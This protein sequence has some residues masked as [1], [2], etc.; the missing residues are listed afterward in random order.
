T[1]EACLTGRLRLR[2][3]GFDPD[4]CDY[5]LLG[6]VAEI[7]RRYALVC[8]ALDPPA[9]AGLPGRMTLFAG[10]QLLAAVGD[11]LARRV[12]IVDAT[13]AA[14]PARL[15]RLRDRAWARNKSVLAHG[16]DTIPARHTE[17]LRLE[18][19]QMLEAYW[20][21]HGDGGDLGAFCDQLRF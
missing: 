3:P 6:E 12:G 18:A 8:Q 16:T 20:G 5:S 13:G 9:Q 19:A 14:D 21:L 11:D 2:W 7:R 4:N 1:V 15:G 17:S 10:A